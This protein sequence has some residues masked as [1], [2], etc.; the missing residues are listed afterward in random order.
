[1]NPNTPQNDKGKKKGGSE[2]P[3]WRNVLP[4]LVI[5]IA[6]ILVYS[7]IVQSTSQPKSIPLSQSASDISAGK[8]TSITVNGDTLNVVYANGDTS[9]SQK[10]AD[11]ALTQSL[12]NHGVDKIKLAAVQIN[13]QSD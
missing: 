11:S 10:E 7:L 8:V 13:I 3:V 6:L 1:M 12:A 9:Q 4:S 2:A 5:F